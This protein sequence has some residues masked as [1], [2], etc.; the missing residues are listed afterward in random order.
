MRFI[1]SLVD[2]LERCARSRPSA[3][4]ASLSP[5]GVDH[6]GDES[7]TLPVGFVL[8]MFESNS[9]AV[10][11]DVVPC[12]WACGAEYCS[13][14]CREEALKRHH[15]LFCPAPAALTAAAAAAAAVGAPPSHDDGVNAAALFLRQALSTNEIFILAGRLIARV[16]ESWARSGNDLTAA[17]API[18]VLHSEPWPSLFE[19]RTDATER[20]RVLMGL[21][22]SDEEAMEDDEGNDEQRT[23]AEA[24]MENEDESNEEQCTDAEVEECPHE[25]HASEAAM[26]REWASDSL[27]ILRVLVKSRLPLFVSFTCATTP[28]RQLLLPWE[29]DMLFSPEVYERLVGA[30]EL[31]NIEVKIDSPLREYLG[32]AAR[33]DAATTLAPVFTKLQEARINRRTLTRK[34]ANEVG[35]D[36]AELLDDA[37]ADSEYEIVEDDDGDDGDGGACDNDDEAVTFKGADNISRD[38][39]LSHIPVSD[40]T[41]LF[42]MICVMN[43]SCVPNVQV[44][45]ASGTHVGT[46]LALRDIKPG[47]ELF[48]NYVD[49]TNAEPIREQD[50][51]HYGFRCMCSECKRERALQ[52]SVGA[53]T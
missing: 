24:A 9:D 6:G 51:R 3:E 5:D 47:E 35:T 27:S 30:F 49:K 53:K 10:L 28:A 19:I 50:L 52:P 41:A 34:I 8:P 15:A 33:S 39:K 16:L 25:A 17:M 40:G 18:N 26:V 42:S 37:D 32:A 13:T 31:N 4:L 46:L 1:G 43:H 7:P 12:S 14:H 23:D 45:Y 48:I 22:E 2:Q 11:S 38:F 21:A 36:V 20:K 29:E 44:A